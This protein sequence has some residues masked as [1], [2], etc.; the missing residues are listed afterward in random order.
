M[1]FMV[2]NLAPMAAQKFSTFFK[3]AGLVCGKG[4]STQLRPSN[5]FAT[6]AAG[7]CDSPPAI[8]WANTNRAFKPG[9]CGSSSSSITA[10]SDLVLPASKIRQLGGKEGKN[11]VS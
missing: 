4:Q 7:P 3:P 10:T 8:G 9:N 11:W 1:A 6:A 5:R 2:L